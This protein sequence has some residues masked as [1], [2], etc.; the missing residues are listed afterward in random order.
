ME[1]DSTE[2]PAISDIVKSLK[3]RDAGREF[4]V[5]AEDGEYVY[6]ADGRLRRIESPKKKKK[7]HVLRAEGSD[8]RAAEKLRSGEKVTNAEL[9][10]AL[11]ERAGNAEEVK[12]PVKRPVKRPAKPGKAAEKAEKAKGGMHVG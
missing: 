9:R 12:K 1:T 10:R 5:T 3:G 11:S 4:F 2:R 7:K 8:S 6:L